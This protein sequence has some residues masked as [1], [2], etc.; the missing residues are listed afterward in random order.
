MIFGSG[1]ISY[2]FVQSLAKVSHIFCIVQ[3]PYEQ[4]ELENRTNSLKAFVFF[5]WF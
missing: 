1:F 2:G 3:C 5:Y 4:I